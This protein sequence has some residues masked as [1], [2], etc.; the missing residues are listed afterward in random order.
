MELTTENLISFF[1]GKLDEADHLDIVNNKQDVELW[2]SS[3]Q[4]CANRMGRDYSELLGKIEFRSRMHFMGE[5][6]L[7]DFMDQKARVE[8]LSKA[9]V[10]IQKIIDDLETFGYVS[11]KLNTSENQSSRG[12]DRI[13]I[14]NQN[15]SV[16]VHSSDLSHET[17]E[18]IKKLQNELSKKHKNKELIKTL[19]VKLADV[20]LDVLEKVFLHSIGI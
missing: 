1:K 7:S 14:N 16:I 19:L 17:Q 18:L 15:T 3:L 5:P 13:V 4:R 9:K 8:D 10:N 20:G 12:Q 11:P 2:W 6:G